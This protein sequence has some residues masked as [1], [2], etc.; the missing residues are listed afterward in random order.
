VKLSKRREGICQ[1]S[2]FEMENL[3]SP[4]GRQLS[5]SC[6]SLPNQQT[7]LT[8][9]N[10]HSKSA[11]KSISKK[12]LMPFL[13]SIRDIRML[14]I[15]F[16]ITVLCMFSYLPSILFS[17]DIVKANS[18]FVFYSYFSN[19]AMNPIV[20]SLM[21]KNFRLDVKKKLKALSSYVGKINI[22]ERKEAD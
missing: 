9:Q 14:V 4:L 7:A 12:Q 18:L 3:V 21:N 16:T 22:N 1:N 2:L 5:N 19:S 17:R 11:S 15:L 8:Q 6:R 13:I 20:Y 10:V